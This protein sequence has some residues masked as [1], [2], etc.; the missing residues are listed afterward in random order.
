MSQKINVYHQMNIRYEDKYLYYDIAFITNNATRCKN[1]VT[2]HYI[3]VAV[4]LQ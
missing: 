4:G 1:K 2:Y 3:N